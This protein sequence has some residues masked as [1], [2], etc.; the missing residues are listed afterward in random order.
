MNR[1]ER[2]RQMAADLARHGIPENDREAVRMLCA[3]NY[4]H[5]EVAHLAGEARMLAYQEIVAAEMSKP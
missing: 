2:L 3:L 5:I 1:Q 4:H